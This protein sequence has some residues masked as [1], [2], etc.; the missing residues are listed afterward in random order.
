MRGLEKKISQALM[1]AGISFVP[2]YVLP[3]GL[4][5]PSHWLIALGAGLFLFSHKRLNTLSW[6]GHT[7]IYILSFY[8]F[9]VNFIFS[10]LNSNAEFLLASAYQV[11][12]LSIYVF[13]CQGFAKG[14]IPT[15]FFLYCFIAAGAIQ[16]ALWLI[17]PYANVYFYKGARFS[18][19]FNDPNQLAYWA[20]C[21]LSISL[22]CLDI[23]KSRLSGGIGLF[24]AILAV[25]LVWIT[26]SRS[27]LIGLV[28]GLAY[29]VVKLSKGR[30]GGFGLMLVVASIS[31][32][33]FIYSALL[34]TDEYEN[35]GMLSSRVEKIDAA[36][37]A[38][39]RGYKRIIDFPSYIILGA[40]EGVNER[41]G[42][43]N[44]IHSTWANLIFSYG[45][46]GLSLFIFYLGFLFR[47][48]GWPIF[49]ATLGP[50]LYGISTHGFRTP[51]FWVLLAIMASMAVR[52]KK[53][54]GDESR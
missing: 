6:S 44:E 13:L 2:F 10:A 36:E 24:V 14:N 19:T 1:L 32:M 4:P 52:R 42:T 38:E 27:G 18:G 39:I 20:I 17:F 11:F 5:Q 25:S 34:S 43:H 37:Q 54:G 30:G 50:L 53:G 12:N 45:L 16:V 9:A 31:A 46:I 28:P 26:A 47:A 49:L 22:V 8:I 33:L 3:S 15:K 23:G 40:G 35:I 41:F 48:G 7:Y 51:I 21:S 29:L